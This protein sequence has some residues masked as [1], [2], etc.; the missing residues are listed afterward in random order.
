MSQNGWTLARSQD[1]WTTH[2]I[3]PYWLKDTFQPYSKRYWTGTKRLL[4]LDGHSSHQHT[5]FDAFYMDNAIV[6][7]CMPP[8]TSHLLQPREVVCVQMLSH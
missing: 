3:G 4:I 8:Y 5:E 6:C 7:L 1:E 2:E